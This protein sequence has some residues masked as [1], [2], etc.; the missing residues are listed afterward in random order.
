MDFVELTSRTWLSPSEQSRTREYWPDTTL[1]EYFKQA[2]E[3]DPEKVA[4]IDDRTE[5]TY[6]ELDEKVERVSAALCRLGVRPGSVVSVQLPNWHEFVIL[7][8]ATQRVGAVINPLTSILRENELRRML[9]VADPVVVVIPGVIRNRDYPSE[10]SRLITELPTRPF[11]VV[12]DDEVDVDNFV[13]WSSF[14]SMASDAAALDTRPSDPNSVCELTF[15]SG[16]SGQPKGIMH[17]ANSLAS[18]ALATVKCQDITAQ[19][20]LH[21]SSAFGHQTAY[22]WGV[23]MVF[24][25]GA[26]LVLQDGWNVKRFFNLVDEKRITMSKGSTTLLVDILD[27]DNA[28]D[29]EKLE[30]LRTYFCGGSPI[31]TSIATKSIERDLFRLAPCWGMS[32]NGPVTATMPGDSLEKI[33]T[34]DGRPYPGME[35]QVR[36]ASGEVVLEADGDLYTRGPFN[37]LGYAQGVEF[38]RQ[39]VSDEG[40]FDTGDRAIESSDGY[41][42]ITGRRKD[43]VVRGG[44]NVPVVEMEELMSQHP[45]VLEVALIGQPDVRLG[46]IGCAVVVTRENVPITLKELTDFLDHRSV[47]RQ[48]MPERLVQVVEL[49]KTVTGKVQKGTLR[50]WIDADVASGLG[51]VSERRR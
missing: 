15:S 46:E 35:V 36:N 39:F 19:D 42:R 37:F 13:S 12:V 51:T 33:S 32:E 16:T 8:I 30:S 2:L 24:V 3:N 50:E 47:T 9:I 48:F 31:P 27:G 26:T 22:I 10:Y 7:A 34:S 40:W 20:R 14:V 21:I 6:G 43:L 17:S 41:I 25:A 29:L 4:I 28:A 5:L 18:C 38:T 11:V 1:D 49:P 45:L 44:E 23:W